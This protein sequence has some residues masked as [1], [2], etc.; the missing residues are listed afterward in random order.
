MF[1][2]DGQKYAPLFQPLQVG[3]LTIPNRIVLCAIGGTALIDNGQ[4]NPTPL[5]FFMRCAK[6]GA[7]LIIPGLTLLSDKWGRPGWLDE[8][9]DAFRGPLKE[10]LCRFH[11]ETDSKLILQLGAGM[12]RGLRANFGV[13]LPYFNYHNAMVA[14]S[15][16]LPNVF[17]PDMKHRALSRDE[18]KKLVDVMVRSAVLAKEAGCDG[19]ELHAI[20]EGYL[21]DQFALAAL[22]HRTD[23]YG[24]SLE[25][26]LRISTEMIQGIKAACG[27]D[28]PVLMRYSTASKTAGINRSV[29]PGEDYTEW[30]RN[31]EESISVVRILEEAG[32][33]AL[34]VDNGTYDS[35]HWC[36]P[37]TYMPE[38][39][40]LPEAAYIKNFCHV[41]VFVSG[42]MGDPDIALKA[43]SNGL[44]DAVALARPFLA[45]NDWAKKVKAGNVDDIRPCIGCHSGC[46]GRLTTGKNVSCALN[47]V[48]LQEK[49]YDLTPASSGRKVMVIGGGIGGMEAAR[50]CALRGLDV[51]LYEQSDRLGGVFQAAAA[52]VFK[53]DDKDL[54]RWYEKQL[55]DL[56]IPVHINTA[57]TRELV[58]RENPET[59][60]IATGAHSVRPPIPGISNP[61]VREAKDYLLNRNIRNEQVV[62]IGGGLTGCETAYD[63]ALQ[64]NR[65]S[66]IELRSEIMKAGDVCAVNRNMLK[67]LLNFRQV[68]VHTDT[69]VIEITDS[70]IRIACRGAESF[71]PADSIILAAGFRPTEFSLDVPGI[72]VYKIGDCAQPGNLL[73]AIWGAADTVASL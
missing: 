33:D 27:K 1:G 24:G 4:F 61:I 9:A 58:L 62:V 7:G 3:A 43:V 26:R 44:V 46:F 73:T 45:D 36:H 56:N 40:N 51:A 8:A 18:I 50:L 13:T 68:C 5:D 34:D 21:L 72:A 55:C 38:A 67:D 22:N 19:V 28:F 65:V 69:E 60:L 54:L 14:P 6:G 25:N 71:L 2:S 42:K 47:P 11:G 31:L 23:E 57:A 66:V 16:G 39:C 15:E 59:V 37:P 64:G 20:H 29:L 52:P 30:G 48:S 41:P 32:V 35:W 53:K 49:Q 63:L 10:Y 17:A 70:G 12:G